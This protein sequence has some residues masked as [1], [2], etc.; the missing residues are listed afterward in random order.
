MKFRPLP[1]LAALVLL[2]VA[3]MSVR[4]AVWRS[5]YPLTGP[6]TASPDGAWIAEVRDLPG[7]LRL[8]SGV[9]LRSRGDLLRSLEPRLVMV[10][11]CERLSTRWFGQRRLVITCEVRSGEPAVLRELVDDV[12]IEMV[13]DRHFG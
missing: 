8:G 2:A 6:G 9:F 5:Q 13:V 3:G 4:E 1:V 11:A 7:N 10:G 12:K